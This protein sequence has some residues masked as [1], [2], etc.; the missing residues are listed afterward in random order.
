MIIIALNNT[1]NLKEKLKAVLNT[2][3]QVS[4]TG[5]VIMVARADYEKVSDFLKKHNS[6]G[7]VK[8]AGATYYCIKEMR[9]EVKPIDFYI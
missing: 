8:V 7:K 6:V 5:I 1:T 4:N 9:I 2:A 3:K